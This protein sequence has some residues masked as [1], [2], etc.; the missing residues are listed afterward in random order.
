[1]RAM[2]NNDHPASSGA[3]ASSFALIGE[4]RDDVDGEPALILNGA[5]DENE[6]LQGQ[7]PQQGEVRVQGHQQGQSVQRAPTTTSSANDLGPSVSQINT[8]NDEVKSICL[9]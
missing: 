5:D 8:L 7:Q 2:S 1:M 4:N 6:H 9:E 3:S